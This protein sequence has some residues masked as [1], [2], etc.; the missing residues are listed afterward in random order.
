[1]TEE[2]WFGINRKTIKW[3]PTIDYD[4]C[5]GC[6]IC[7]QCNYDVFSKRDG[8]PQVR[9]K[10]NCVVGCTACAIVCPEGAIML[11][12]KEYLRRIARQRKSF[13]CC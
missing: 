8:K 3:F 2:K 5:N 10:D 13:C 1:M 11:P 12:P 7:L 9:N 6:M 4:I